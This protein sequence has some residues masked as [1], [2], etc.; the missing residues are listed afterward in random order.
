[1]VNPWILSDGKNWLVPAQDIG[2]HNTLDKIAGYCL[3][4]DLHP[5]QRVLITTGRISSEMLQKARRLEAAIL[6]SRTSPSALSIQLAQTAGITLIGYARRNRF[7]VYTHA[8][9]IS[10]VQNQG[11]HG[12]GEQQLDSLEAV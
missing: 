7:N 9:R 6:I 3:L 11:S 12:G 1:M 8:E 4:N 5:E 2:R 10:S